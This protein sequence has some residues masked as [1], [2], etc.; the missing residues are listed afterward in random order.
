MQLSSIT[1]SVIVYG[2]VGLAL[3][4][5]II[6]GL[7]IAKNRSNII[8]GTTQTAAAEKKQPAASQSQPQSE[9]QPQPSEDKTS[10]PAPAPT[11]PGTLGDSTS[12]SS[13]V[14]AT[15][16]SDVIVASMALAGLVF[17]VA[18]YVQSRR[19]LTALG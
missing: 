5:A 7:Q 1:R 14:P 8:G 11:T 2:L 16:S 18:I 15:G 19:R 17:A 13:F 6:L 3:L 10:T 9:P 12:T 4:G